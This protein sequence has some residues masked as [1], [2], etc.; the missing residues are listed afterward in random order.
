MMCQARSSSGKTERRLWLHFKAILGVAAALICSHSYAQTKGKFSKTDQAFIA[1]SQSSIAITHVRIVDGT[2]GAPADDMTL[3]MTDGRI[4]NVVHSTQITPPRGTTIIDGSGKTLLPGFV[5]MHEH[6]FYPDG[7]GDYDTFPQAFSRLYLAGGETTIRTAGSL[8]PYADLAVARAIQSGSQPGPDID[9]SGPYLDGQPPSVARMPR[10]LGPADATA[11][12]NYWASQGATSFKAYEH[13][14]RAELKASI[15][16]AHGNG[17]KITGHLCSVTYAEAASLGIDNLEHS[18]SEA[19]D[20]VP[21]KKPD[22][23]PPGP[24][25]IQSLN[26]LDPEGPEIGA[27][28]QTLLEHHVALTSTLPIVETLAANS[29]EPPADALAPLTPA[30]RASFEAA[31]K[32]QQASPFGK[33]VAIML[34][35]LMRMEI[36]FMHAGGLL[37]AGSDPTGYGGV[38]PGS[39][40]ARELQLLV[41]GGFSF[42]QAVRIMTLNGAIY[43]GR[44]RDIG[45]IGVGKRADLVL[46]DGNPIIDTNS[47]NH[48][49][50]VFKEG[51]GYSPG[52]IRD[53]FA[54]KIGTN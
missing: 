12:V 53:A 38:V 33:M 51:I 50:V 2:G 42:P 7:H 16:A 19:S 22:V 45:S 3:V 15:D 13:I 39:S 9:A 41:Q 14:T 24:L 44:D 35:R 34:P 48:L 49:D 40:S 28:I 37:M 17:K 8:D 20:F 52:A 27:L 10:I 47:L 1:Y 54:G 36:R 29:P 21:D 31:W 23:C 5:M 32:H 43:L 6:L 4:A 26:K 30:F 25:R 11:T 18:F 46:V